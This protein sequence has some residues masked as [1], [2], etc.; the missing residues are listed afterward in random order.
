[1][2]SIIAVVATV[3]ALA[4]WR[5]RL[6][7]HPGWASSE[8]ARF[9]ISAGTWTVLIALYWYLQSQD[10]PHWV[11]AIWPVLAFIAVLLLVRGIDELDAMSDRFVAIPPPAD[12]KDAPGR[13]ADRLMSH[14]AQR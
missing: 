5:L 12:P 4:I 14:R 13:Y 2:G 1:M 6:R 10:D 3:A 11:W 8:D 9:H 7:R